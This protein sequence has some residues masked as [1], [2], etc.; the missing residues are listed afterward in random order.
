MVKN[1]AIRSPFLFR[2]NTGSCNGCDVELATT[3]M[4][5]RYDVE[6]LGCRYTGSPKH[7]DILLVTGPITARSRPYLERVLQELPR[8]FVVVAV[9]T[10]PTSCGIFRDSYAVV[11]PLE[12][13]VDVDVNVPGCPPRPQAILDGVAKA[14]EIWRTK[15][16]E[17]V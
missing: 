10:C 16:E 11:G 7:A 1:L 15:M 17:T 2:V 5:P 6:R 14:L 3:A 13:F 4:I 8:P 9:G 12:R